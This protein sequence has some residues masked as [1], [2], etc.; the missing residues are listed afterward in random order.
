MVAVPTQEFIKEQYE[1]K[2]LSIRKIS[3]NVGVCWRT[4]AKYARK[5]DW[6]KETPKVR[7][8]RKCRVMDPVAEIVDTWIMED[9]LNPRKERRSAAAMYQ[10]LKDD[11]NFQGSDRTVR[12]YVSQRKKELN[13]EKEEK[14]LKLEHSPGTAQA[15]FGTTHVVRDG[16]LVTIKCLTLSFPYSNAG[17]TVPLPSENSQCFLHGLITIFEHIGGVPKLISFDNLSAA[18]NKNRTLTEAF[19]RCMLHYRYEAVFC[20]PSRANEKGNCENKVGY[21]RR[22]FMLPYPELTDYETLTAVLLA[23]AR[24]DM[25]RSH[26]QKDILIAKLFEQDQEALLPLPSVPFE[27]VELVSC[28]VDKYCQVR[29]ENEVYG[30][31]RANP[32][33]RVLLRVSWDKVQVIDS[34]GEV[35]GTLNRK[36]TLKTQSIDWQGYFAIFVRK[37]RGARHSAMYR[38]LPAEL[39][40]YLE[41]DEQRYR[42]RLKLIHGFLT[43]GYRI[44]EITQ[45]VRAMSSDSTEDTAILRHLLY[46]NQVY[47]NRASLTETY[48]PKSVCCYAPNTG[49][50]DHLLP[51]GGGA[52]VNGIAEETV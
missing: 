46:G 43:E 31:P 33:Q 9:Q 36:Y 8:Q 2:D 11:H 34:S 25:Q 37:P 1:K 41:A 47:R 48:T 39:K 14:F 52:D 15:D 32:K 17:F 16:K 19:E 4:A 24:S 12:A 26:Y 7:K 49:D 10:T 44:E 30:V 20:N 38:F 45:A 18:I 42:S 27:P 6:N 5:D 23:R 50:Y 29:F 28:R 3:K 22:N 40:A 21:T 13:L 35:L 51:K